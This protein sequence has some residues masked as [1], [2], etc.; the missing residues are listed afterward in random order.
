[1]LACNR[2]APGS[3]ERP[4]RRP[5]PP[6]PRGEA[7]GDAAEREFVLLVMP[8]ELVSQSQKVRVTSSSLEELIELTAAS[9]VP[10]LD[11]WEGLTLTLAGGTP[12]CSFAELPDKAKVQLWQ[13]QP[14]GSIA[15]QP[16]G[17]GAGASTDAAA[18]TSAAAAPSPTPAQ[19]ALQPQPVVPAPAPAAASPVQP[20][21]GLHNNTQ[22]MTPTYEQQQQRVSMMP[23]EVTSPQQP[24]QHAAAAAAAA[25]EAPVITGWLEMKTK[26][27]YQS[28]WCEFSA[29]TCTLTR[30]HKRDPSSERKHARLDGVAVR[31]MDASRGEEPRKFMIGLTKQEAMAQGLPVQDGADPIEMRAMSSDAARDWVAA[32]FRSQEVCGG[33]VP[34]SPAKG[35]IGGLA[36]LPTVTL[37]EAIDGVELLEMHEL[38][39][40]LEGQILPARDDRSG[41]ILVDTAGFRFQ[42]VLRERRPVQVKPDYM[43]KIER[44]TLESQQKRRGKRVYSFLIQLRME[45]PGFGSMT[46]GIRFVNAQERDRACASLTVLCPLSGETAAPGNEPA[47]ATAPP[48]QPLAAAAPASAAATPPAQPSDGKEAVATPPPMPAAAAASA[49]AL[50]VPAPTPAPTPA[51][52]ADLIDVDLIGGVPAIADIQLDTHTTWFETDPSDPSQQK[53]YTGYVFQI[54]PAPSSG[55]PSWTVTKRYSDFDRLRKAMGAEV[56][57]IKRWVLP[58]KTLPG[59]SETEATIEKRKTGLAG[60]LAAVVAFEGGHPLVRQFCTGEGSTFGAKRFTEDG[61]TEDG[62][63]PRSMAAQ[64]DGTVA[65]PMQTASIAERLFAG[66]FH[67]AADLGAKANKSSVGKVTKKATKEAKSKAKQAN[68]S[69]RKSTLQAAGFDEEEME[70]SRPS[71]ARLQELLLMK[72]SARE[73]FGPTSPQYLALERKCNKEM[74]G[75]KA[76]EMAQKGGQAA[77]DSALAGATEGDALGSQLKANA[78]SMATN[79][80]TQQQQPPPQQ[81]VT[82]APPARQSA[83]LPP[84]SALPRAAAASASMQPPHTGLGAVPEAA[85]DEAEAAVEEEGK[86]PRDLLLLMMPN[87][88]LAAS[89]KVRAPGVCSV[90][91]L[92]D[93]VL[94]CPGLVT[95]NK[96]PLPP[97]EQ[98][99]LSRECA[100]HPAHPTPRRRS[101]CY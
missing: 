1:L 63:T 13:G 52:G 28:R 64:G 101:V 38:Q 46:F 82:S 54:F 90:R 69:L 16:E 95:V 29:E 100:A 51:S 71:M 41:N 30:S 22:P 80:M 76:L 17:G 89:T 6:H 77:V 27:G 61:E 5:A 50:I 97:P 62:F 88:L 33:T 48:P 84:P 15:Q 53:S 72:N 91:Q 78:D 14:V 12:V 66:G 18:A 96:Q 7:M 40:L 60:F 32:I 20:L 56:P 65:T 44:C 92:F 75:I 83:S 55:M 74:A 98:L 21:Q 87:T 23:G 9:I 81:G 79:Y 43:A 10:P 36:P 57:Q 42:S 4:H 49:S 39:A 31:M 37:P 34:A 19:Q 68:Q 93:A 47:A 8:S 94:A 25:A 67:L 73:C 24:S 85:D 99:F 86:A 45:K 11:T 35:A 2:S 70:S 59:K 3:R 58:R 26:I